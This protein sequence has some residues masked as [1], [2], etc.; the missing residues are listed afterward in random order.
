[1]IATPV[2]YYCYYRIDPAQAP[3]ARAAVTLM[4]RAL[5]DRLGILG[6]LFQGERDPLLWMEVYEPLREGERP[7]WPSCVLRSDSTRFSHQDRSVASS[8][9][10]RC[11]K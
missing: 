6:R 8:A 10:S 1:M 5:E 4:F 3:A 7:H 2:H 11:L 9:S